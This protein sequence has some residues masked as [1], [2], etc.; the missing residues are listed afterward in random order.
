METISKPNVATT[1]KSDTCITLL[2]NLRTMV[3]QCDKFEYNYITLV[4]MFSGISSG[5]EI[6]KNTHTDKKEWSKL[7]GNEITL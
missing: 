6:K 3:F 7:S 5:K 2:V 1:S 4:E